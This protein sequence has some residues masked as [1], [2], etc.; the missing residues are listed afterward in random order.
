L[1]IAAPQ[2]LKA[3]AEKQASYRS[4]EPL[5]PITPK[6]GVLGV[7]ALHHPKAPSAALRVRVTVV[8]FSQLCL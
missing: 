8:I 1:K 4:G 2:R 3:V 6:P 5:H 7:P